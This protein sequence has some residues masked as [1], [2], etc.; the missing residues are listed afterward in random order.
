[1]PGPSTHV[2]CQFQLASDQALSAQFPPSQLLDDQ[3]L[4]DQE[5]PDH[6][7]PDHCVALQ[8]LPDQELPDQQLPDH[9]L[10][11]QELPDHE[12]PF[13][14]PPDQEL[15]FASAVAIVELL[16]AFPKMSFSPLRLT[17]SLTRWLLPRDPSSV[18]VPVAGM[19]L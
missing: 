15:A 3:E 5:L 16:N 7:L 18:P 4:P 6:E 12:L 17:P 14:L 19:R 8:E 11:D 13:Q 10:P 9:E 2:R 1:V